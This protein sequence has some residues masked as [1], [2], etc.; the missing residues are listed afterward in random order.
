MF[1]QII[2]RV[3]GQVRH[4]VRDTALIERLD[5]GTSFR[6]QSTGTTVATAVART[7]VRATAVATVVPVD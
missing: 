6:G 5:E 3:I 4:V 2:D 7:M 1:E